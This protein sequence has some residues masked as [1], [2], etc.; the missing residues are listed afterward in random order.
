AVPLVCETG[1]Q[2][3]LIL[4][5]ER[6]LLS[7][8]P[9]LGRIKRRLAADRQADREPLAGQVRIFRVIKGLGCHGSKQRRRECSRSDRASAQHA[10]SSLL[11][12]PT[13]ALRLP[14][15]PVECGWLLDAEKRTGQRRCLP[16]AR[17]LRLSWDF[18]T[19]HR[20]LAGET[21]AH[22]RTI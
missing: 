21:G 17:S 8:P 13:A 19:S 9:G 3:F 22:A 5:G 1:L 7:Q 16:M 20:Q 12:I 6:G 11:S 10:M 15:R 14:A 4:R 2:Y 18:G